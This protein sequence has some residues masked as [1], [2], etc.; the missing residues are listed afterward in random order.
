MIGAWISVITIAALYIGALSAAWAWVRRTE[1]QHFEGPIGQITE[2][3]WGP[4]GVYVT[5]QLNEKGLELATG[6]LLGLSIGA[7]C[8]KSLEGRHE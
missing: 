3:T 1:Y 4:E 6:H 5:A 7:Q 8:E 2:V